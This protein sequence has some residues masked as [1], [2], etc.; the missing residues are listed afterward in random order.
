[1]S[2]DY[3]YSMEITNKGMNMVYQRVQELFRGID[4]SSNRFEGEIPESIGDLKVLH[5]F[6]VSNNFLS[7]TTL[8]SL[9]NLEGWN[10]WT[11]R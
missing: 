4:T 8:F 2:Y 1:M 3:N 5:L 7:S 9:G 11:F 6:N 10:H